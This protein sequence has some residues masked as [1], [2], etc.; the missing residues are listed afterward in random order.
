M[1]STNPR[2]G[3]QH[4]HHSY[5]HGSRTM[6]TAAPTQSPTAS[7]TVGKKLSSTA[8]RPRV[9]GRQTFTGAVTAEW[10]KIWTLRSTWIASGIT[11]A[12]TSLFSTLATISS[13]SE[14]TARYSITFGDSI[15]QII[16]AVLAALVITGEY[17]S[18]QIRSSLTAVPDRGRL[19]WSKA[20]VVSIVS[21]L[22]G[23]SSSL[24]SWAISKPF[25]GEHAGSLGD[26][27]YLG[28]VWGS[29][30]AFT[31]IALLTLAAGFL[32]RSTAGSITVVMMLLF[33]IMLPLQLAASRWEWINNI[34]GCMPSIVSS[35][36]SD[37]FEL[38]LQWGGDYPYFLSHAQAVVVFVAWAIVPL[39]AA[40]FVFSR[41]DA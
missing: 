8:T 14:E 20:L 38:T 31:G 4:T 30:L 9:Q 22:L 29:G 33:V 27:H 5:A 39:I 35:A 6:T 40:W 7:A 10:I 3:Q 21:F 37:P 28:L 36:V 11:I 19:L 1:A 12:I 16:V 18:G 25:L 2:Y 23:C 17:S 34:I 41:R 13:E 24:L 15:G 32:L 26:M